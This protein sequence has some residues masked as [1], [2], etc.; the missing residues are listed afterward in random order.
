[1]CVYVSQTQLCTH[2]HFIIDLPRG[3]VFHSHG[4]GRDPDVAVAV[5]SRGGI[6][7]VARRDTGGGTIQLHPAALMI[8]TITKYAGAT[9]RSLKTTV[10]RRRR[11]LS[12]RHSGSFT[13]FSSSFLSFLPPARPCRRRRHRRR[14]SSSASSPFLRAASSSAPRPTTSSS[15]SSLAALQHRATT[16]CLTHRRH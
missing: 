1:M 9:L 15:S 14:R 16:S 6:R 7:H 8:I 10:G 5:G 11:S 4:H 2:H 12:R 3:H 13:S